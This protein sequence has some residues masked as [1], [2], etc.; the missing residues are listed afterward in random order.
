[1][2]SGRYVAIVILLVLA[3]ILMGCGKEPAET[4]PQ[5]GVLKTPNEMK[6]V[7]SSLEGDVEGN[8]DMQTQI[9]R[10][11]DDAAII[12]PVNGPKQDLLNLYGL[13]SNPDTDIPLARRALDVFIE[14]D[15]QE[16]IRESLLHEN[17]GI[18][19]MAGRAIIR[20][21]EQGNPDKQAIPY[22]MTVLKKN[23]FL[24]EGREAA[25]VHKIL[26][27]T[28]INAIKTTAGIRGNEIN[29]YNCQ[30]IEKFLQGVPQQ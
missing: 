17:Q 7:L 8:P 18:V 3:T 25:T 11:L 29:V 15:S 28:L 20:D 6:P 13:I 9:D 22:L 27:K 30:E 14:L 24:Q 1:M 23:N 2:T 21:A 12:R 4:P 26:K 10:I 16:V 5:V 19:I